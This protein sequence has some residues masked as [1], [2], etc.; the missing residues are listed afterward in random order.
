[1]KNLWLMCGFLVLVNL[2]FGLSLHSSS[3]KNGQIIPV[4]YTIDGKNI[5]PDL[6]WSE[7]PANTQSYALIVVDPDAPNGHWYHWGVVNIPASAHSLREA[8]DFKNLPG[9]IQLDN[10]WGHAYYE[11]PYP[12]YGQ[13]HHYHF[14]LYALDVKEIPRQASLNQK[15]LSWLAEHT[16]KKAQLVGLYQRKTS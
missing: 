9:V 15:F 16:L 13:L 10:S 1:M 12:P 14:E 4:Q 8:E 3:F 11:G 6:N 2:S 7:A 5:S